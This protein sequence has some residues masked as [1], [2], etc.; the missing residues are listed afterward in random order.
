MKKNNKNAEHDFPYLDTV[1]NIFWVKW[2][3]RVGNL[4]CNYLKSFSQG[5]NK[6]S[7]FITIVHHWL[8][9]NKMTHDAYYIVK[10]ITVFDA[11][12]S[13]CEFGRIL[14]FEKFSTK[15]FMKKFCLRT[16][17]ELNLLFF[18]FPI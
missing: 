11:V 7:N 9:Q 6:E 8:P 14:A 12:Q 4:L 16:Y 5:D 17:F 13:P 18:Y 15:K 2:V 10:N 1:N 3:S